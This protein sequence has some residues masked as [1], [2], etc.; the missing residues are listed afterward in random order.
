M[1]NLRLIT[2]FGAVWLLLTGFTVSSLLAAP[3]PGEVECWTYSKPDGESFFALSLQVEVDQADE[4]PRQVAILVDTSASQ[5]GYYRSKGLDT[6]E[7]LLNSLREGDRVQ[8]FAADL[9][10]VP[11]TTEATAPDSQQMQDAVAKLRLRTPLGAVDMPTVLTRVR[12]SFDPQSPLPKRVIYIGDGR[13]AA[14][15]LVPETLDQLVDKL[16][17]DRVAVGAY[18]LGDRTD[19]QLLGALATH[20]GGVVAVDAV[21]M[22]AR[23]FGQFLAMSVRAEVFW[24]IQAEWPPQFVDVYPARIPPLRTDR[25]SVLIGRGRLPAEIPIVIRVDGPRRG[26]VLRWTAKPRPSDDG[27]NFLPELVSSSR[28]HKGIALPLAGRGGLVEARLSLNDDLARLMRLGGQ[29]LGIAVQQEDPVV[30]SGLLDQAE[31]LARRCLELDAESLDAELLLNTVKSHWLEMAREGIEA[32]RFDR[33]AQ[34]V[35]RVLRIDPENE[36]AS[37]MVRQLPQA[38]RAAAQLANPGDPAGDAPQA[39]PGAADPQD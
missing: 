32:Q 38:A 7:E 10:A 25:D 18:V 22:N 2:H 19:L 12:T 1:K 4:G 20:T 24:P 14:N 8:L 23:R 35:F 6:L 27:F 34:A 30:K 5:I 37:K 3:R 13:S 39:P 16:V 33:A 36:E 21:P 28:R 26:Q 9:N 15:L 17:T 31:Q 11:M 29:A